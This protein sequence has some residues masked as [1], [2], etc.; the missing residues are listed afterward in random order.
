[1]KVLVIGANGQIGQKVVRLLH[2]NEQ[3]TVR[4]MVRKE[5]QLE[6]LKNENIEA[7]YASLEGTV[8]ELEAA[9]KGCDAVVFT[10]GSGGSTGSDKTLLIDL[11]GAA[12]SIEAAENV[13]VNRFIMVS[14]LQAHHRENWNENLKPYYVAKHYADKIL[15]ASSLD[16]T[17]IRP[18][19]LTNDAG[20]GKVDVATNLTRGTIP[21][22]DV[23]KVVVT[24]LTEEGT[25]KKSFDLLAGDKK[26]EQALK[27]L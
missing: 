19:G 4:A 27:T 15:E 20:T 16:Y 12:K 1:M 21:R 7:V 23:A 18:G 5:E 6:K 8:K 3:Y 11:D 17:I 24:S 25:Y 14:A 2:A 26:I 13:G 22:E 9:M 10:A